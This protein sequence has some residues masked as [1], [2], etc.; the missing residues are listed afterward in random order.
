MECN[1]IDHS[2]HVGKKNTNHYLVYDDDE[3]KETR[4][5]SRCLVGKHKHPWENMAHRGKKKALDDVVNTNEL[6]S[7]YFLQISYHFLFFFHSLFH[8]PFPPKSAEK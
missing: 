2:I 4:S 8:I 3:S 5:K 7:H 6:I 1:L